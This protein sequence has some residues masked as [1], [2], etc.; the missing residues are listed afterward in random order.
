MIDHTGSPDQ[1]TISREPEVLLRVSVS[2]QK[3]S[4]IQSGELLAQYDVSTSR[5]GLGAEPGS[6]KT[7]L[8]RFRIFQ[9]VGDGAPAGAV[10]K[11]RKFTGETASQGGDEDLILTRILWLE[12]H[13]DS[14][15]GTRDRYIYLH[16]TNQESLIGTPASHGCVRLRNADIIDL[17]DKVPSGTPVE[18][19]A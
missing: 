9:K 1:P 6:F 17:Y 10:F 16:G 2:E 4:L 18:I 12:D 11:S 13:E 19:I 7:P 14:N 15:H 3:L 5:F 8:G